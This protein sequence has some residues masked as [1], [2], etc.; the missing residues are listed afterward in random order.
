MRSNFS[1]PADTE[2]PIDTDGH[3]VDDVLDVLQ[4]ILAILTTLI[5]WLIRRRKPC[6]FHYFRLVSDVL[7]TLGAGS[8][9]AITH[10]RWNR[11]YVFPAFKQFI[12]SVTFLRLL[13][14]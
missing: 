5:D 12:Q 2:R 11:R 8:G 4:Q 3:V 6:I 9:R 7:D 14:Q 13:C 10:I 1:M